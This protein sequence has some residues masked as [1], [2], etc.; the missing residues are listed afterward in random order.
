MEE[1]LETRSSTENDVKLSARAPE[2]SVP[3]PVGP[4]M[5]DNG[6]EKYPPT[7]EVVLILCALAAAI[8]LVSLVSFFLN[9]FNEIYNDLTY[10]RIE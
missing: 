5:P 6:D 2:S 9:S 7:R 3:V 8:F 1:T 4:A 10:Y